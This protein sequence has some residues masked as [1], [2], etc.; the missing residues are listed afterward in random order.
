VVKSGLGLAA[1]VAADRAVVDEDFGSP[2]PHA[3]GDR[4]GQGATLAEE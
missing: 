1:L 4:F 3:F 2:A